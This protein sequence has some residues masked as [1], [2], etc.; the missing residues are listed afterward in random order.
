M[1]D[2]LTKKIS[3][4]K[5]KDGALSATPQAFLE[6]SLRPFCLTK[7]LAVLLPDH[8]MMDKLDLV[9]KK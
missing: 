4:P 3:Y 1:T 8:I 9:S 7:K 2:K 5:F 6:M